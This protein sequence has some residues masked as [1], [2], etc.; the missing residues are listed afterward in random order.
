MLRSLAATAIH[1]AATSMMMPMMRN[2]SS[3]P[4]KIA[5]VASSGFDGV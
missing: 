3:R 5:N 2:H 4:T 1:A